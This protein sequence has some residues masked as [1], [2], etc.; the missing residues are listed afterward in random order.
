MRVKETALMTALVSVLVL[1]GLVWGGS[2]GSDANLQKAVAHYK[3]GQY[4]E[5]VSELKEYVQEQPEGSAYY[6]MAYANYELGKHDLAAQ[7]FMDAYLVEP[8]FSAEKF[9][10]E[11]GI[12][13]I[14]P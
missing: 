5:A 13:P 11:I 8:E 12:D 1:A 6:L 9:R 10:Q 3:A 7:N 14:V 4:E 2:E